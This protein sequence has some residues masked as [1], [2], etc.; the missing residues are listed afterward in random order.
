MNKA[1]QRI[2]V[3][4]ATGF[5]GKALCSRLIA[6]GFIVS[7]LVRNENRAA[8]LV[9]MGVALIPGSLDD[10][11]SLLTLAKNCG[12]VIHCAGAVRGASQQ[13]FDHTNV[14]GLS[15]LLTAILAQAQPPALLVLSS[16][17]AREPQLSWYAMSKHRAEQLL[18]D[19]PPELNWT[20]LRPTAV[21][22]PGDKEMLPVFEWMS[23]GI[24]PV[25]G[26][27]RARVSLIHV[28]DVVSAIV[29]CLNVSGITAQ[30]YTLADSQP[31]GYTWHELADTAAEV[32]QRKVRLLSLP[33]WVL[34]TVARVNFLFSTVMGYA[35]MLTPQKLNELRH[36]NWGTDTG[37]FCDATGWKPTVSLH[38]GLEEIR[39]SVL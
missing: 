13:A 4:G 29:A 3:T 26:E 33:S 24:A 2:A 17:A 20:I 31:E 36:L 27:T 12:T 37:K 39:D 8:D 15:H 30:T 7:A 38:Q 10:P 22:G 21:Y 34:N 11:A 18:H 16:L 14:T 9:E 28:N 23:R 19:S 32:W 6:N 1:E 5:I 25:P 35:P